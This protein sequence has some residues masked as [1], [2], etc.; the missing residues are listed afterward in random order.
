MIETLILASYTYY[1]EGHHNRWKKRCN[2]AHQDIYSFI[3]MFKHEQLLA[4]DERQ[5][6]EAG[7]APPK[8]RS[9]TH[10]GEEALYRLW[11][12]LEKIPI[13]RDTLF[14]Y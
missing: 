8:R 7:A 2:K 13:N 3:D 9:A 11:D 6:H 4:A 1:I 10:I 12:K 5:R 14:N